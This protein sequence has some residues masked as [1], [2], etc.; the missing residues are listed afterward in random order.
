LEQL[1]DGRHVLSIEARDSAGNLA[2]REIALNINTNALDP[3]G[4]YGIAPL[5]A[6]LAAIII[7]VALI[8]RWSAR[9]R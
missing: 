1:S 7:A 4:P 3:D 2:S 6:I 5:A 9:Y 8:L